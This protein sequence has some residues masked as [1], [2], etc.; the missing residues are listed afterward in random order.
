[1]F[2]FYLF[3]IRL[4]GTV[5]IPVR[6]LFELGKNAADD[7]KRQKEGSHVGDRLSNLNTQQAEHARKNQQRGDEENALTLSLIHI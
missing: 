6:H 2:V 4:T 7:N 5:R 1:M 3:I